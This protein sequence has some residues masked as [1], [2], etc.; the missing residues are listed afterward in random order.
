MSGAVNRVIPII[1]NYSLIILSKIDVH[2]NN[3]HT[4][5]YMS[6]IMLKFR[7]SLKSTLK[8][9]SIAFILEPLYLWK[10]STYFFF[11][12]IFPHVAT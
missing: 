9:C 8:V 7:V 11:F 1:L 12:S 6:E 10:G 4:I 3:I 5:I 2:E